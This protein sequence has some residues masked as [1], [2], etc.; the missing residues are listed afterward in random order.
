LFP[1]SDAL[2]LKSDGR[3]VY[4]VASAKNTLYTGHINDLHLAVYRY[5]TKERPG[6]HDPKKLVYYEELS[7]ASTARKRASEI[8]GWS[9]KEKV[10]LV[11]AKN[12]G[13]KDLLTTKDRI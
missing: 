7:T 2:K 10:A 9:R 12:P 13:W 8:K 5:R 11:E 3:F 1:W 6:K 4:I